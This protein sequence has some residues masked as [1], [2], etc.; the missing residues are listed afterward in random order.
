MY[1]PSSSPDA[2]SAQILRSIDARSALLEDGR[3][4][5]TKKGRAVDDSIYRVCSCVTTNAAVC[6]HALFSLLG[7]V[8][9][10]QA[11][12]HGRS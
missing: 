6:L 5:F 1:C 10:L 8:M 2:F 7:A 12:V 11:P 3:N 4:L 9:P